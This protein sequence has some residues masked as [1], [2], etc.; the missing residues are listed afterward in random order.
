MKQELK[1][2]PQKGDKVT[3]SYYSGQEDIIRTVVGVSE[4][5]QY[6][7]G[8]GVALDGGEKC[9]YCQREGTAVQYLDSQWVKKVK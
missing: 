6:G 7:S 4:S 2:I 9:P 3:T 1:Y 5:N 8:Y